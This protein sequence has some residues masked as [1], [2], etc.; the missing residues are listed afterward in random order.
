M[1][2]KEREIIARCNT[3]R[4]SIYKGDI[5]WS[6]QTW[7]SVGYTAGAYG[8]ASQRVGDGTN[9]H[10]GTYGARH[11]G[12]HSSENWTQCG[13]C[14]D[15]WQKE[16]VEHE[17]WENKKGAWIFL[18]IPLAVVGC[19]IGWAIATKKENGMIGG[20]LFGFLIG[21]IVGWIISVMKAGK[22]PPKPDRYRFRVRNK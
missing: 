17:K 12:T 20:G 16:I 9:V 6:S 13:W 3:C 11:T 10:G 5:I 18:G 15:E 8:G 7:E 14:Y 21:S 22:E 4:G 2:E 1:V 19:L